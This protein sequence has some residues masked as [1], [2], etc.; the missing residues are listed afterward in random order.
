[1]GITCALLF[2]NLFIG[3]MFRVRWTW[4]HAGVLVA[5]GGI[6]LLLAG[7]MLGNKM[8]VAVDQVELPPGR[9]V[10]EQSLPV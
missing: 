6:L 5:H 10:H 4:R 7:I 3:G 2:A 9:R 8:T 1:M